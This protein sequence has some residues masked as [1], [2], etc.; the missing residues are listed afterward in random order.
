MA[1]KKVKPSEN[2]SVPSGKSP[3]RHAAVIDI[4]SNSVRMIIAEIA[5]NNHVNILERLQ[6]PVRLGQDTFRR[7]RLSAGAMRATVGI[8]REFRR[9]IDFYQV[10]DIRVVATS[11]VREANNADAFLDRVLLAT[12]LD[13]E[14]IATTEES[15]LTFAAVREALGERL[16]WNR[17][18]ALLV[19]VGGG[20]TLL[21]RL[22]KGVI[23][24]S[25]SLRLGSVR[26][27]EWL[28]GTNERPER[29]AEILRQQI[30]NAVSG[31][32]HLLEL[33][34][35]RTVIAVGG[36][37]RFA[38]QTI[39]KA[40]HEEPLVAVS[41]TA[42]DRLV[43]QCVRYQPEE[44]ARQHR[45]L[46]GDAETLTPALLVYQALL[47]ATRAREMLV[48]QVS[49]R[50]GLLL[51]LTGKEDQVVIKGVVQSAL[52][53]AEKYGVDLEHAQRVADL[54]VRLFD[55]LQA[56]HGLL[57]RQRLVL[58]VAALTHEIGGFV[59]SRAHHK[60]SYYLI[61]N[62]EIFGLSR[63]EITT[64][65]HVARYH[66]RSAPKPSHLE[67]ISLSRER[68]MVVSK[69][70]AM[71]R[72]AD[73]LDAGHGAAP[74]NMIHCARQGENLVI[75]AQAASDM[76]LERR[77]LMFKG[78]MFEDIY[79]L[80]VRLEEPPASVL[81]SPGQTKTRKQD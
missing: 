56:E 10:S 67:Y 54:A 63:E 39:G 26:M 73:A 37:A 38:A 2:R 50:E 52:A 70:A 31:L 51:D 1:E 57:A 27:R 32:Q 58:Q 16:D 9:M 48:A 15:R 13:V 35:N 40:P 24:A 33:K 79:G 75:Y 46:F 18:D 47:H 65:A 45:L 42:L 36:D 23:A 80:K 77:S 44:L 34:K 64:A 25:Q 8:L 72:I 11:A 61:A 28:T 53:V 21:T 6:Q 78:D 49:M 60:H 74:V 5:A 17:V 68:R 19:D 69:L 66:R 43:N 71:L 59:S 76:A 62:S 3:V 7:G 12:G 55:E 41:R 14:V 22:E 30:H 20:S 29:I 4:G 81:P